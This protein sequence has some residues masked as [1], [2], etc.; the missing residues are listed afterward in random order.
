MTLASDFHHDTA[1]ADSGFFSGDNI[2]AFEGDCL[3]FEVVAKKY[4][5]RPNDSPRYIS[6]AR[7]SGEM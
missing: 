4:S 3:F 5:N 7:V 2:K 6:T 1:V